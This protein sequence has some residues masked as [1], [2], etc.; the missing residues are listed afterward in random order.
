M[1]CKDCCR[2]GVCLAG[3]GHA[4]NTSLYARPRHPWLGTVPNRQDTPPAPNSSASFE[5]RK[6]SRSEPAQVSF[7][8]LIFLSCGTRFVPGWVAGTAG[9]VCGMDAAREPTGMYS[10]RVPADTVTHP[11]RAQRATRPQQKN[12]RNEAPLIPSDSAIPAP[13]LIPKFL[14]NSSNG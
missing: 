7:F 5:R 8:V 2:L 4:V 6:P 12:Q 13:T 9:T 3:S 11:G 14:K 10:R 1:C